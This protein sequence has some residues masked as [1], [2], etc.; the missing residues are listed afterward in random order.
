MRKCILHSAIAIITG[1]ACMAGYAANS[2]S[3]SITGTINPVTCDVTLSAPSIDL[4]IIPASTLALRNNMLEGNDVTVDVDC[5]G[6]AT[7]AIQTTDNRR[8]SAMTVAEVADEFGTQSAAFSD[9][10][11]FGLGVDS[12]SKKVGALMLGL[13]A[14]SVDGATNAHILVGTDKLAWTKKTASTTTALFLDKDAYFASAADANASEPMAFTRAAYTLS[15][16]IFLRN[17]DKYPA[18]EVVNIDGS[19][20]FSVVYL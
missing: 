7:I 15:S 19:I 18:G 11:F 8:T 2:A 1:S 20:T 14:A 13:T 3:L 10:M 6:P 5:G 12:A 17:A 16:G 4:G 9:P